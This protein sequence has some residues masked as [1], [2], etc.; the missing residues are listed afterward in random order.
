MYKNKICIAAILQENLIREKESF[1]KMSKIK[2]M[3][4]FTAT[5][6]FTPV[7]VRGCCM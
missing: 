6:S 4:Y 5:L 1:K 2:E 3:E 7:K